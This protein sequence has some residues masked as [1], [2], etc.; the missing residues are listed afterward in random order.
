M[1]AVAGVDDAGVQ[2]AGEK[3][4][5]AAGAVADDDDIGVERLQVFRR[6]LECFALFE[7]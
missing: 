5:R 6:V 3:M 7:R 4:R 2:Q 1:R